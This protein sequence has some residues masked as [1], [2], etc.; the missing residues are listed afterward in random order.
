LWRRA[1]LAILVAVPVPPPAPLTEDYAPH[2]YWWDGAPSRSPRH[3]PAP[4][5]VDV[6][7]VGGGLTGLSAAVELAGAGRSVAVLERAVVGQGA[8]SRNGGMVHP[9][10]KHDLATILAMPGGRALWDDTVAAFEGL[11]AWIGELGIDCGWRRSG[12][13]EL[14]HHPRLAR[15]LAAVAA[16]HQ[17]IGERVELLDAASVRD[18]VGS[19]RFAGGLVVHRSAAL[20]PGRLTAGVLG[21]AEAAG[22]VLCDLT[23][24]LALER[25]GPV[26][27]VH[28]TRGTVRAGEVVMAT[29]GT[30]GAAPVPWLGRRVLGVGSFVIATEPLAPE[31]VATVSRRARMLFD[32]RNFLHYWRPSPDGA[33]VLFGGRT[34]FA[35]TTLE[36]ARDRLHQAMVA[37]HPQL[38]GVRVARAW[39]GEVGLTLDRMP[40]VGRHPGSGVVFALG[41]C[42]TGVAL[43]THFGRSVGRW[44][45]GAGELP[46]FAGR[47]F[48]TVPAPARMPRLLPV[49]GW[50]YLARDALGR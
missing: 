30:T 41:Y 4:A 39:G 34:S 20:D 16:A 44:L 42:G 9:G 19:D 11:Q 28:T 12:H 1:A 35:P 38:A 2:P 3:A 29:D 8:S 31:L 26:H 22:A 40:H 5:E 14:A 32:T 21:A 49:A 37:I 18:E 33:R 46:A 47:P 48:R 7:V 45:A 6:A 24:V 13:V 36:Q 10:G 15:Q 43:S 17:S 25:S 23:E 50:W 27:L